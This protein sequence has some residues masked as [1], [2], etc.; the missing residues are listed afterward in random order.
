[1]IKNCGKSIRAKLLNLATKEKQEYMKILGRY[2][3]ERLLYRISMS[4]YKPH[5][6][7]KGSSLLYAHYMFTARPTIDIDFLGHQISNDMAHIKAVFKEIMAIECPTDG[8]V[9][10]AE[11]IEAKII[12]VEKK[13]PG[14]NLSFNAHLDTI[15][16]PVS[17]DIGFGDVVTP[18]PLSLNYP[19]LINS[20]PSVEI[21]SY[22]LETLIA[23]KFHAMIDRDIDN[24][25]MKD[26]YDVYHLFLSG[27]VNKDLL[28]IAIHNTFANRGTHYVDGKNLFEDSFAN[29]P[30]RNQSWKGF[31]KKLRLKDDVE[32]SEV[33]AVICKN[34][35]PYW[36]SC[37]INDQI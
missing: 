24:S 5:L 30:M 7:L 10:D 33:M 29:D 1:M 17:I 36:N 27:D 28:K 22:S 37:L 20:V 4:Q 2:F 16:Y 18:C 23:E 12:A 31:L 9:F 11:S 19:T 34:L 32:F 8:V 26:F 13:Y 15:I 25:R 6:L 21:L 35:K 3:H 14:I